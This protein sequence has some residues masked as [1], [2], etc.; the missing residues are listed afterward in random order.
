MTEYP[1]L[2]SDYILSEPHDYAAPTL[3]RLAR[4]WRL[5]PAP[6]VLHP[7]CYLIKETDHGWVM[8]VRLIFNWRLVLGDEWDLWQGYCFTGPD[9]TRNALAAAIE[10]SGEGEAPGSWYKAVHTG[11]TRREHAYHDPRAAL[12]S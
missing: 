7:G 12:V 11:E 2:D 1:E 9:S 6:R 3:W 5:T 4:Q 8:L 10:W